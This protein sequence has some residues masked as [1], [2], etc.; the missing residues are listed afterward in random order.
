MQPIASF[1]C[2]L[3]HVRPLALAVLALSALAR[4]MTAGADTAAATRTAPGTLPGAG[5]SDPAHAGIWKAVVPPSGSMLGEFGGNDPIG[6]SAGVL[7]A[8]DCSIN[9]VDPDSRKRYCFSSATSLVFFQ[10]APHS[11]LDKAR[12]NWRS[13]SRAAR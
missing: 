13:L 11:Y 3:P 6:L 8:A 1:L 2:R 7:I 5:S 10:T 12:R 9:W 4:P